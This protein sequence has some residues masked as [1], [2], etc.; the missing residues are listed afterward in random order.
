MGRK[1][2]GLLDIIFGTSKKRVTIKG[3]TRKTGGKSHFGIRHG[4][5]SGK[6]PG[7]GYSGGREYYHHSKK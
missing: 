3:T 1:S 7:V 5:K 6:G 2:K 4:G